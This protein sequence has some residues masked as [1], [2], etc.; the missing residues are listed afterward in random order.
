M[1]DLVLLSTSILL[2]SCVSSPQRSSSDPSKI[3]LSR[4]HL[5]ELVATRRISEFAAVLADDVVDIIPARTRTGR[6]QVAHDFE[7]LLQR[8]PDLTLILTSD[9][10]ETNPLWSLAAESGHWYE[11]WKEQGDFTELRGTYYAVW[12]L[13]DGRWQL[14]SQV[15]TPLSC[16]GTIYCKAH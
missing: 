16:K 7:S 8:R 3:K 9:S 14:S 5:N 10:I 4:Q 11:S 15:I 13:S 6:D 1:R 12:K 2:C